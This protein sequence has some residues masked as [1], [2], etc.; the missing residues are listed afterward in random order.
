[1]EHVAGLDY[2]RVI[3]VEV[4]ALAEMARASD[5]A[6]QVPSCP[7]WNLGDLVRHVGTAHRWSQRVV[8]TREPVAPKSVDRQLPDDPAGLPGWLEEGAGGLLGAFAAADPDAPC[9][10]WAGDQHVRFWPRRMAFETAVHRW[11]ASTATGSPPEFAAPLAVEGIDEH[12]ANLPYFRAAPHG[13]GETLHLHCTDADGEWLVRLAPD[14]LR[15]TREHTKADVALRGPASDLFLVLLGR[16]AA[17][18]VE[19]FGEDALPPWERVF[20][21]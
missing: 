21:F 17:S 10:T 4:H 5:L 18:T 7:E 12:L 1:L 11:D 15:V 13:T 19:V 6:A 8:E 3:T 9:W 14:G 20:G 16:R 2:A